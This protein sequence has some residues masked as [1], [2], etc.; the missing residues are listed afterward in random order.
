MNLEVLFLFGWCLV[1]QLA[2]RVCM[3]PHLVFLQVT[4]VFGFMFTSVD[5]AMVPC[6]AN[7]VDITLVLLQFTAIFG[8][9]FATINIAMVPNNANIVDMHLV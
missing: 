2:S 4:S 8:F 3:H 7:I 5:A 1:R 6:Y 9:I